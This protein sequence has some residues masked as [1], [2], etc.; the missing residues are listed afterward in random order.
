MLEAIGYRIARKITLGRKI[1]VSRRGAHLMREEDRY[2]R[3]GYYAPANVTSTL[4]VAFRGDVQ[5]RLRTDSSA[6]R[7]GF[8]KD[9][10]KRHMKTLWRLRPPGEDRMDRSGHPCPQS[11][12]VARAAIRFYSTE[13]DLVADPY[14]GEGTTGLAA[15]EEG[16]S[17]V[18][19]E[20]E[21]PFCKQAR[22]TI[23]GA[24]GVEPQ[25][26]GASGSVVVPGEQLRLPM[27]RREEQDKIREAAY[28][29][30][31]APT[32][33]HREMAEE[34]S[35]MIGRDV[36]PSLVSVFLRGERGYYDA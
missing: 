9:W 1:A 22:Q 26:L 23:A 10:A 2:R 16:R 19:V 8:S 30:G 36:P 4:L 21:G 31:G 24:T 7:E 3:P 33:R 11:K 32:D 29:G 6:E 18:L 12:R 35:R 5:E 20:R 28:P 13:G 34:M 15:L 17:A 14:A 27:L 25:R